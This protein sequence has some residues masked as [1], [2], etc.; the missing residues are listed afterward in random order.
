VEPADLDVAV[1]GKN[2]TNVNYAAEG[3][4]LESLGFNQTLKGA[5]ATYGIEFIKHF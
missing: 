2:I 1:F 5:P 4:S 3:L